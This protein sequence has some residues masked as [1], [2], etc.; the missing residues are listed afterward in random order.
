MLEGT[1]L[2]EAFDQLL[3]AS[4]DDNDYSSGSEDDSD[5]NSEGEDLDADEDEDEDLE[6]DGPIDGPPIPSEVSLA[7]RRG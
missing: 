5:N 1:C 3:D 7:R 2:A 6:T 4:E